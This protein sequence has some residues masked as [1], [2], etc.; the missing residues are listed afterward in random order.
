[1]S[2]HATQSRR[3]ALIAAGICALGIAQ[4]SV[5]AA[6]DE[7][8]DKPKIE[9]KEIHGGNAT[10]K[11]ATKPAGPEVNEETRAALDQ[12]RDTYR[13][14]K[15]LKLKATIASDLEIAGE[16]RKDE[17]WVE[18]TFSQP[19]A[20]KGAQFR[21]VTFEGTADQQ[22]ESLLVGQTPNQLFVFDPARKHYMTAD[23]P[24]DR[25]PGTKL[26][27]PFV[28]LLERQNPGLLLALSDDAAAEILRGTKSVTKV[29]DQKI[30][31]AS[32]T[33]LKLVGEKGGEMT[34]LFDGKTHLL[35]RSV[36]D[37]K[38]ALDPKGQ[39]EVKKSLVTIDYTEIATD[40]EAKPEQFAWAPPEGAKDV[41][42][43]A[44]GDED[45]GGGSPAAAIEGQPAPNFTLKDA[46]DKEI[47]LSDLKGKVVLLDFWA[48]W[49]GPCRASLPELDKIYADHKADAFAPYAVNLREDKDEVQKFV[50]K[51][52]L[53]IPVLFD[54]KGEVA[55]Q[56]KVTGIPQTV[57]IGKDGVVKKVVVG[58][59][60]HEA[61]RKAIEEALK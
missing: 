9:L 27:Q 38:T 54:T 8:N 11:P 37:M 29:D 43:A 46:D 17:G 22:K 49:C 42:N 14:V 10:A 3:L 48:T 61:V 28:T 2:S 20:K 50:T 23:A 39:A 35:R 41:K 34:L 4:L 40:T 5:R 57:V 6:D 44:D 18:S 12:I 33:A 19:D 36:M 13:Q 52:G 16:K 21:H 55:K 1:M 31:G 58:S 47:S 30:D 32:C 25:V 7:K 60:T 53:K 51:T 24:K 56:Y 45:D 26:G 59:G 15:S